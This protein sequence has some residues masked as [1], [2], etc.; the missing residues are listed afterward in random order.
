MKML[1]FNRFLENLPSMD[2]LNFTNFV[3]ER[4]M[5]GTSYCCSSYC[6][7]RKIA[8]FGY[9]CLSRRCQLLLLSQSCFK[10]LLPQSLTDKF[11]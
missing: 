10:Q 4:V 6:Y 9:C 7:F 5:G 3:S 1:N 2:E 8:D 11:H